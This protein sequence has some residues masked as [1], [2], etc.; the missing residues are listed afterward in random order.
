MTISH[1]HHTAQTYIQQHPNYPHWGYTVSFTPTDNG[2][3]LVI[4]DTEYISM[5][6]ADARYEWR[7]NAAQGW[8]R[9]AWYHGGR[10]RPPFFNIL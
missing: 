6:K 3:V 2:R 7:Q 9:L 10:Q 5:S 8:K 1:P 4:T